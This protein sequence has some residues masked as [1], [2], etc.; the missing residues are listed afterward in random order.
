MLASFCA[1]PVRPDLKGANLGQVWV[2]CLTIV[3]AADEHGILQ[4]YYPG[5][6]CKMGKHQA[7]QLLATRQI[8]TQNPSTRAQIFDFTGCGIVA[9][10]NEPAARILMGQISELPIAGGEPRLHYNRTLLLDPS[11]KP[12]M[13]LV[14]VGFQRLL[15]GWEMAVPVLP[16]EGHD[17]LTAEM[18]GTPQDRERTKEVVHDLRCPVYD[19]RVIF[20]LKCDVA[21]AVIEQWDQERCEKHTDSR[22]AFLR[23][24]YEHKPLMCALPATWYGK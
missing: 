5:D 13:A 12:N 18:I 1:A 4:T 19:P 17:Y 20:A 7:R 6:W 8:E 24:F 21:Q 9:Y 23:A 22:L 14:P 11:A 3:R 15:A 16:H 2:K 10:V